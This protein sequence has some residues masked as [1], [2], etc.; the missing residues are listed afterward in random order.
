MSIWQIAWRSIRQRALASSLTAFSM[1]LGVL[2]VTA[3]LLVHGLITKSFTDN[4]NLGYDLIAGAKGGKLQLVLNTT[5]YLSQPVENLPYTFYQEFLTKEE[6]ENEL[7]LMKPENRG[8]LKDGTYAKNIDFAIPVNLG[9]TYQHF[10]IVGTLPKFFE[11]FKADNEVDPKYHFRHGRNFKVWDDEHGYFEA[12]IGSIVASETGLKVGDKIEAAHGGDPND[13]HSDSPFIVVGILAPSGTPNDRAVFINMEGF[14]LMSG[15][16]KVEENERPG[17]DVSGSTISRRK[18]LPI[19]Q[20]EVTAILIRTHDPVFGR[21]LKNRVNEG[22]VA[23]IA[24]PVYVIASL[25]E[26]IVKPI[27]TLLLVLTIMICLVSGISI[28]VSIYNSMNDR[29]REIAIMRALGA[30]RVTVMGIVL[31]ESIIL[32]V[33]GGILG[34][35]G[36]HL[37]L[38]S[39][40]PFVE[41]QTGVQ[42]GLFELAPL[43]RWL[44]VEIPEVI[45]NNSWIGQFCSIELVI[46]PGLLLLAVL[47]GFLP[48]YTA[49][50]TDV[51]QALSSSP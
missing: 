46:I 31:G 2:L 32:S 19:K 6:Q 13:V 33:G 38:F 23:Q 30:R 47:V 49:Y 48:A 39:A 15:H 27:Q 9:D 3:V 42:I 25:F 50:R 12:V 17:A 18:P 1:A 4:S 51:A 29:K 11:V 10:R 16:A 22:N 28:L 5:F 8:E 35:M 14:Y 37:L 45:I 26:F 7:A 21:S 34:W 24:S 41:A 43:P 20:R 44:E 40:S 36:A